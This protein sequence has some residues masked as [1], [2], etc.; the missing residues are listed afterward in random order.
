MNIRKFC[1]GLL[2]HSRISH[3]FGNAWL[4]QITGRKFKLIGGSEEDH[5]AAKEWVSL[6]AHD[7]V[8]GCGEKHWRQTRFQFEAPLPHAATLAGFHHPHCSE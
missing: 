5:T 6:F 1:H 8:F 2:Q 3:R 4:I 7:I